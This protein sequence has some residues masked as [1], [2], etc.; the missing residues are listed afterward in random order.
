MNVSVLVE[1]ATGDGCFFRLKQNATTPANI[2]SPPTAAPTPI[3]ALAPVERDDEEADNGEAVA[4][5]VAEAP[6]DDVASESP[7]WQKKVPP[8]LPS[9]DNCL[10]GEQSIY[11]ELSINKSP[12][13]S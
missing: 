1:F 3:P 12:L 5:A 10:N 2:S 13:M 6:E 11:S 4:L 8:I 9:A 7:P